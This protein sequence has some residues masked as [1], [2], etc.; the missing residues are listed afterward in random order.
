[1]INW[2]EAPEGANVALT[3]GPDWNAN[4]ILKGDIEFAV[5]SG[6]KYST[7]PGSAAKFVMGID[8]WV[9]LEHRPTQHE[10]NNKDKTE[11]T[12]PEIVNVQFNDGDKY[13]RTIFGF[14]GKSVQVDVY[15]VLD[16][17]NT[18]DAAV[19]HAV[20][21]MLCA[22]LRGHK[23]KITDYENAIESMQKALTLLKQ[24]EASTKPD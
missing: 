19:D 13:T 2:N 14:C 9:V 18:E 21:K 10:T 15:R 3:T 24:K 16:A 1:M 5:Y 20:K 23:G 7:K 8:A 11:L 4:S 17:F 22:G 12:K 6:G